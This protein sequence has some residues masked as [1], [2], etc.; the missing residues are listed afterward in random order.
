M[1]LID[2]DY[3]GYKSAQANEYE[4]DF[5]HDVIIAQSNFYK[6]VKMYDS[7]IKQTKKDMTDDK[8]IPNFN[9]S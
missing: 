3:T 4:F 2:A 6:L 5:G 7:E 9:T 8:G 1:L